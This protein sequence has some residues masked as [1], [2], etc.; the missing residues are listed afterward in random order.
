[1]KNKANLTSSYLHFFKLFRDVCVSPAPPAQAPP[2][3]EVCLSAA[4]SCH[5]ATL[6]GRENRMLPS[7]TTSSD[8]K[9]TL[10]RTV[11]PG[12]RFPTLM[13]KT[14]C[15]QDGNMSTGWRRNFFSLS[16]YESECWWTYRS[17]LV[18]QVRSMTFLYRLPVLPASRFLLLHL[19]T[20]TPVQHTVYDYQNILHLKN[21]NE[22]T[23]TNYTH[24]LN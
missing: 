2:T 19:K 8:T 9:V 21:R 24:F 4:S 5:G 22:I 10:M 18:H 14:S 20:H 17:I 3:C 15:R 11:A 23:Q 16:E 6:P 13:V 7:L 1:M 12:G